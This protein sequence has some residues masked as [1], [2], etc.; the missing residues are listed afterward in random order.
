MLPATL[1]RDTWTPCSPHRTPAE[2]SSR[3]SLPLCPCGLLYVPSANR[4]QAKRNT[5]RLEYLTHEHNI[6]RLRE[7]ILL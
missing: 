1:R 5:K 2:R 4:E 6:Q 3:A 7:E